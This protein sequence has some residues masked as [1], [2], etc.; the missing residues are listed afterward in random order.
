MTSRPEIPELI[1]PDWPAPP[2]VRALSTT[3]IGGYSTGPYLGFNLGIRTADN[4]ASVRANRDLL[5]RT[6]GLPAEPCWLRQVHGRRVIEAGGSGEDHDADASVSRRPGP[7]CVVTTAD[8]M[9]VLLCDRAGTAVAAAHAGWRGLAAGVVES[10]LEALDRDPADVLAWLGPAIGPEVFEVGPEVREAFLERDPDAD[11][12]F[13]P[14]PAGRWLADLYALGRRRL[15]GAGVREVWGGGWCT[16]T[17]SARFF[18]YRR[19]KESGRMA[20][21]IWL[22]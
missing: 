9:P 10:A 20:T 17:D 4:P 19:E 7:V 16:Y 12:C 21:M 13:R 14:S 1:H 15:A 22:R 5:A 2:S 18:S 11:V 6:A 8:C 3:R